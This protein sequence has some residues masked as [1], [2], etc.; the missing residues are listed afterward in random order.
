MTS[1]TLRASTRMALRLLG[2]ATLCLPVHAAERFASVPLSS[3]HFEGEPPHL[4][5]RPTSWSPFAP[6]GTPEP[7]AILE[8]GGE[9]FLDYGPSAEDPWVGQV[10]ALAIRTS[11]DGAVSGRLVVPAPDEKH[12]TVHRFT[13]E[14][15]ADEPT[16]R[17]RYFECASS[18]YDR[19]LQRD[20][21][22]AAWFRH[23]RAEARRALG[24]TTP[25]PE[26]AGFAREPA[27]PLDLF[28]GSRAIAENL[29]L[30]RDLRIAAA[31]E[32]TIDIDS[33]TGVTTK[34][35]D[36]KALI[37]D[38]SPEL[39]T[40]AKLVPADQHAVF[41]PSFEAMVRVFD[42]I[43]DQGT[44]V[45]EFFVE[46]VEDQR[47]KERYQEQLCLPLST[48]GR[49]LGPAVVSSV[50]MTGSDPFLPSG[51][52][53]VV[54]F[55]CKEPALLESFI[56]A[57]HVEAA[58]HGA[59]RVE[60]VAAGTHYAGV[61][62]A[63]RHVSS[64]VAR[65]DSTVAIS[66]S[67]VALMRI[68]RLAQDSTHSLLAA[69]EYVWFRDRYRKNDSK[70]SAL[71]VLTDATIRRWASPRC[72]L[73]DAR[74]LRAAAAMAEIQARHVDEIVSGKIEAG[75]KASDPDFPVSADFVWT[76][77]GVHSAQF[78]N[79]GFLTPLVELP[80]DRVSASEK[81]AYER[82]RATFQER[83]RTYF[84][85]IALRLSFDGDHMGA[86]VTILPLTLDSEYKELEQLTRGAELP[87]GA[88]DPHESALFHFANA[89]SKTSDLGRMLAESAGPV[90]KA[91][92]A[93][94]L[95]WMG[96]SIALYGERDP[97]WAEA[98]ERGGIF[99]GDDVDFY[100][101][102]VVLQVDVKDPL[103][104]AGFLTALRA[105]AD[106]SAPNLTTWETRT[107]QETGYVRIAPSESLG[108]SEAGHDAA[109]YYVALPDALV[110]SL[111]ED[112]VKK[113][114]DRRKSRKAGEAIPGSD[115]KWLGRSAGL[116]LDREALD[117]ITELR[118]S[119]S[120]PTAIAA[121]SVL[122]IL[123]E[124]KRRFPSEDPVAVHERLFGVRLSS[125][126]G[127]KLVWNDEFQT[128]ESAEFG[129]PGA[130]KQVAA[131]LLPSIENAQLGLT[132]EDQGLRAV[133]E[134]V[135]HH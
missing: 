113:A 68:A 31:D 90:A 78:G 22:G 134:I 93:D 73:G 63:D 14:L 59:E 57:R 86:D 105:L 83:W 89:F 65:F 77:S 96:A 42:G 74:R 130:P 67:L 15:P 7:Y 53:V 9:V 30:D 62:S 110:V 55:D 81:S 100:A 44:P 101:L 70:E 115:R 23:R 88:G 122:P 104:L 60:G 48:I 28:S 108:L 97:W 12:A 111:R 38:K 8:G 2:L 4:P 51:S 54:L 82:F 56:T 71:L 85:P 34:A 37:K 75:A 120:D 16:A 125:P 114:I 61:T 32:S 109:L 92:G 126:S 49:L 10:S 131:R 112:L 19:L 129:W 91:F 72:R 79:L 117:V 58:K 26:R 1:R 107:W 103:K 46:R 128:M 41:F 76:K 24:T 36:W 50:A 52:D 27:D 45:L 29:D 21:P 3:L 11:K 47:T 118:G 25:A 64:Y 87:P 123:N 40:L 127:G 102:P 43:E 121:W 35:L 116:R 98:R 5:L 132:F 17:Q 39:D 99:D 33:I 13:L 135:K 95:S 18:Y 80:I 94:P 66:N 84:D 20:C 124:W 119:R 69:D 6:G 133:V 106:Q